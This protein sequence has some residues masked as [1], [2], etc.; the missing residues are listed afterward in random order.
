MDPRLTVRWIPDFSMEGVMKRNTASAIQ[1]GAMLTVLLYSAQSSALPWAEVGD[2]GD[3]PGTSQNTV[4]IGSLSQ[5]SVFLS[6]PD[7]KDIF[8]IF[9]Q[10]G[11]VFSAEVVSTT[12][13][14]DT[15]LY[16]LG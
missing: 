8:R 9:I 13:S 2:A 14:D 7:D 10:A 6:L 5:I 1:F 11:G 3:L 15:K 4:G 16:L 12:P